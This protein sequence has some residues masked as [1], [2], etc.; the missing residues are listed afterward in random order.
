MDCKTELHSPVTYTWTRQ[1]GVLP[2]HATASGPTLTIPECTAE[3]AG[4]YVCF[5]VNPATSVDVTTVLVVTGAVPYFTQTPNSFIS[6][7]TL[8]DSY[9]KFDIEIS[10]KPEHSN[11]LIMYNGQKK[12]G[13][14]D[15]ISFGLSNGY[16]EFRFDVGAG[17]AVIRGSN[18]L[19]LHAWHTVNLSRTKFDGS[20][21]VDSTDTYTGSLYGSFQGL[22]LLEPLFIGGHPNFKNVHRLSGQ[23]KGFVGCISELIIGGKKQQLLRDSLQSR[24]IAACDTCTQNSC[25][26]GAACQ[27]GLSGRGFTCICPPGYSGENCEIVGQSC[28][29]GACGI[30]KCVN[31]QGGFNCYCPFG[32]AGMRCDRDVQIYEPSF[33]GD[34]Y[35]SYP[36]PKAIKRLKM[37]LKIKPE[38]V[39]EDQLIMYC[40]QTEDGLGDYTSLAIKDR[41]L[42]FQYDTGSGPA[43]IR[44]R[45]EVKAGEWVDITA[46]RQLQDGE[47]IVKGGGTD[48]VKGKSPGSNR[49]LNLKT[50]FFVGGFD[51]HRLQLNGNVGVIRGFQG[52]ISEL[53]IAGEELDLIRS[54][55]EGANVDN[56]RNNSQACT[57]NPCKNGGT[58]GGSNSEQMC[59]CPPGYQGKFCEAEDPCG[60][61]PCKNGG[62]C[63]SLKGNYRCSC[64]KGYHGRNCEE[65]MEFSESVAFRG[66]GY[67]EL[68]SNYLRTGHI[69]NYG[70][71]DG[72]V[73]E[74]EI[75][76]TSMRGLLLFHGQAPLEEPADF[77]SVGI[78]EE[79]S[80]E[81][82]WELGSGEAKV[83]SNHSVADGKR[84]KVLLRRQGSY[85]V[86][87]VD[88]EISGTGQS[89]GP[90]QTLESHGN[91]FLGGVPNPRMAHFYYDDG[92]V[93]CIHSVKFQGSEEPVDLNKNS[94]SAV[95]TGPC[96]K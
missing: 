77:L 76:T 58:C 48:V 23:S 80:I 71:E 29:P 16:P 32:K 30:G 54:V 8:P 83:K 57:T 65:Q 10:F 95:N 31:I 81:F 20:M 17:P 73:I 46:Q 59:T 34:S 9:L 94:I 3:D 43:V 56:C 50:P 82:R 25:T 6:L 22:D 84:H 45:G 75:S 38:T 18:P 72:E 96:S 21:T 87:E 60:Q 7:P 64:L 4:V 52:C 13:T 39:D 67:L 78:D 24:G 70:G 93:G 55:V 40:S 26:N 63:Y 33:S 85:G 42:E 5:A 15:F 11:G 1:G 90:L 19:A 62:T 12:D 28:Y 91:I 2:S 88:G 35:L 14:G 49:G 68:S 37:A 44:S 51:Q 66:E 61:K 36:T 69:S 53:D 89:T 47:L 86:V 79:G 74:L 41:H 92:F 27:E